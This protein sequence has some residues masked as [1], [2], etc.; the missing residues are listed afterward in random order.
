MDVRLKSARR[1][2][3]LQSILFGVGLGLYTM[4]VI[5]TTG[6]ATETQPPPPEI[7]V[8]TPVGCEQFAVV[9]DQLITFIANLTT[10][11]TLGLQAVTDGDLEMLKEVIHRLSRLNTDLERL[12]PQYELAKSRCLSHPG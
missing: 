9:T 7:V 2:R 3:W 6:V 10:T 11:H 1:G 8:Q 5:Y 12:I 4:A